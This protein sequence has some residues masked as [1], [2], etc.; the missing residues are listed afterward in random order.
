MPIA[1]KN[2][3]YIYFFLVYFVHDENFMNILCFFQELLADAKK[4]QHD[5]KVSTSCSGCGLGPRCQILKK[6]STIW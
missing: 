3:K 1:T 4:S 2:Y 6:H 5:V